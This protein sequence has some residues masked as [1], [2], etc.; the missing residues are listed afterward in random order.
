MKSNRGIY[1]SINIPRE[2]NVISFPRSG[3]HLLQ[4]I[5]NYVFINHNI[6][7]SFCE[8]YKCCMSVPCKLN[9][10]I[11]KNHDFDNKYSI[12]SNEKYVVLY[13]DDM[14]LQLEA[15][16]RYIIKRDKLK[17]NYN[18]LIGFIQ[19]KRHYYNNFKSKWIDKSYDNVLKIEYYDLV[20]NTV[21]CINKIMAHVRPDIMLKSEII[22]KIPELK[23]GEYG[24]SGHS[25][26]IGILNKMPDEL[27]Q[28]IKME[29][30]DGGI[31]I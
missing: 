11:S 31:K 4:S 22:D 29:L 7:Y 5:L 13:R 8:Y 21:E 16:Y 24:K 1:K 17:Y 12:L 26:S 18:E 25:T 20:T 6:E 30:I 15:F 10:I 9:K 2:F 19:R 27:Y 23:F 28:K 3:Q 14:I